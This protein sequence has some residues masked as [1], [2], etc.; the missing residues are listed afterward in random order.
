[1]SFLDD[2][3]PVETRLARFWGE[4]PGGRVSTEL[5]RLDPGELVVFSAA[6]YRELA[7]E[8]PFATGFA[9]EVPGEGNVNRTSALEN[10][11][12]SAIGRA[13]ANG[14]YAPKGQRPSR[15]EMAK[16]QEDYETIPLDY[17]KGLLADTRALGIED[18]EVWSKLKGFARAMTLPAPV[19]WDAI[20][21]EL[22][23][24][25]EEWI[26]ELEEG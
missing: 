8:T 17:V 11:E 10:C 12:T 14:G 21:T 3:E 19:G 22:K 25:L 26:G 20:H 23:D 24:P 5:V 16:T 4:H 7:D 15:E 9:H 13:L 2:Y 6:L 1:M 18:Q